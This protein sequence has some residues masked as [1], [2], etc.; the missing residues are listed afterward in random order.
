[1]ITTKLITERRALMSP[2]KANRLAAELS[3]EAKNDGV[4]YVAVHC[5]KGTGQ[6]FV[7]LVED[8]EIVGYL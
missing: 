6:S 1:M 3:E 8:G 2:E 5:P 7:Q 4:E